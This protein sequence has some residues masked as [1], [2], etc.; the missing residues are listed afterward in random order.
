MTRPHRKE[1]TVWTKQDVETLVYLAE[2]AKLGV[3]GKCLAELRI[4]LNTQENK[5]KNLHV[6]NKAWIEVTERFNSL[7]NRSLSR[8]QLIKKIFR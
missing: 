1:R 2:K 3:E 5:N 4:Q 7:T 6:L 8:K